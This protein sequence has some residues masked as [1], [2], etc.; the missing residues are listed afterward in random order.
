MTKQQSTGAS[1]RE[2]AIFE[3]L[4]QLTLAA[5]ERFIS[6]SKSAALERGRFTVALAGGNTPRSLYTLLAS[7][8]YRSRVEWSKV[9]FFWS[10][11]RSVPPIHKDSN[12]RMARE[13]LL[14]QVNPPAANI[15]RIPAEK[16][17]ASEAAKA[18]AEELKSFFGLRE[19]EWPRFDLVLLGMG[20]DG[21]TASLFPGTM[22]LHERELLVAAPWV[23]K[24]KGYRITLTLP[25]LNHAAH[26]IFFVAGPEKAAALQQVL[27]GAFQPD[28]YPAQLIHPADGT[29]TWMVDQTAAALLSTGR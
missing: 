18:Y 4:H 7:G 14:S 6:E 11:E 2:I 20:P 5:A 16:T 23:D 1:T 3:S 19:G 29:V 17:I 25:A 28:T 21:H 24:F 12:F 26:I 22:V 8:G 15:H 13:T 9:H 27:E 10:D